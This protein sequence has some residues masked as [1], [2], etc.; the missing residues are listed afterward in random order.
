MEPILRYAARELCHKCKHLPYTYKRY[1]SSTF[2]LGLCILQLK[3]CSARTIQLC[4]C[5]MK[6][7]TQI[8]GSIVVWFYCSVQSGTPGEAAW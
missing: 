1:S 5:I 3:V 6:I 4:F 7:T 2:G 8:L